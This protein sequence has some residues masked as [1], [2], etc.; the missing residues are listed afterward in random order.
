MS[1]QSAFASKQGDLMFKHG[2][3]NRDKLQPT[4]PFDGSQMMM[5]ANSADQSEESL[6][7][8]QNKRGKATFKVK[9]ENEQIGIK[10]KQQSVN[11]ITSKKEGNNSA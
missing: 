11:I 9:N 8:N 4:Q 2:L 1:N 3:A 5:G 6:L 7:Y 10:T